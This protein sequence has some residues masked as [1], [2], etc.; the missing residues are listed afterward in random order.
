MDIFKKNIL[1]TLGSF[2]SFC[3]IW[4]VCYSFQNCGLG[5]R[6]LARF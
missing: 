2:L 1:I 6:M 4:Q 5:V 3:D